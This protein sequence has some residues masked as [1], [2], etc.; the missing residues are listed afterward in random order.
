MHSRLDS[1]QADRLALAAIAALLTATLLV[2]ILVPVWLRSYPQAL[3]ER[4][5]GGEPRSTT[6]RWTSEPP[7]VDI[8]IGQ[9]DPERRAPR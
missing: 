3:A 1:R 2:A 5:S 4:S 7:G 9:A 8:R 6:S